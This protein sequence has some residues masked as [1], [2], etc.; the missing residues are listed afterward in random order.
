MVTGLTPTAEPA[1]GTCAKF[2]TSE[3]DYRKTKSLTFEKFGRMKKFLLEIRKNS[4]IEN[5][6]IKKC[7]ISKYKIDGVTRKFLN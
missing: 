2:D 6:I 7:S 1:V 3:C 5:F 4:S